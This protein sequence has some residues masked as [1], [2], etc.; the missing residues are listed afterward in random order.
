MDPSSVRKALILSNSSLMLGARG[1]YSLPQGEFW[2]YSDSLL[3]R[4][5][6]RPFKA[7]AS[8]LLPA[9]RS[10]RPGE[11]AIPPRK[12]VLRSRELA[13][14]SATVRACLFAS[15]P[16]ES[17]FEWRKFHNGASHRRVRRGFR[18]RDVACLEPVRLDCDA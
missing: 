9:I 16:V 15:E 11:A 1:Q 5:G 4:H 17:V 13:I 2:H 8:R 6:A 7:N 10:M 14:W 12:R 18:F 3:V